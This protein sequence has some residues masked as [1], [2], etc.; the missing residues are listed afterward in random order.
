ML[1]LVLID[2][3]RLACGLWAVDR[4]PLCHLG[5]RSLRRV[6][7]FPASPPARQTVR[8]SLPQSTANW[9]ISLLWEQTPSSERAPAG[10]IRVRSPPPAA[11]RLTP[12]SDLPPP[13]TTT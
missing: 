4:S 3:W 8:R 7:A 13:R 11:E 1:F 5:S 2:F 6:T 10:S 12:S 9:C